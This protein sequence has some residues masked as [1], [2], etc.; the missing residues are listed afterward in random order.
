MI[1]VRD[2]VT[3]WLKAKTS[4]SFRG[5]VARAR[6][7]ARGWSAGLRVLPDFLLIG[8]Q[9]CGTSSLYTYLGRHP[10]VV[11]S[12]RKEVEYLST[13]F[14]E[15]EEWYRA[16]FPMRARLAASQM[17]R[18]S[19]IQTFEAT[20][21]YMLDPRAP[22]RAAEL[23]PEARILVLVRDPVERAYSQFMHNRRLGHE[24]LTFAEALE[25]EP[26]RTKGELSQMASDPS[27]HA[28]PLRRFGYVARGRYAEQLEGWLAYY[29][30]DRIHVIQTESF[31][32]DTPASFAEIL[33][34][35]GLPD[36]RPAQFGNYS[37]RSPGRSK[38]GMTGE[39]RERLTETFR[40]PNRRLFDLLGSD[41]G[42][43]S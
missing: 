23:L 35:L 15:G 30:R 10:R 32:D 33:R 16:H 7:D 3:D 19:R 17:V 24:Q 21:D 29:P 4:V 34:F 42:W 5:R 6:V 39:V 11:P 9:R 13:R 1:E 22:G 37:A 18:R 8:A 40:E 41:L 20:P 25:Q 28:I 14:G 27:Y 38:K 2:T 43:E 31:F 36:W 12:L 26:A